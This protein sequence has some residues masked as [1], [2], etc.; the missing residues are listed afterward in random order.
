V[1]ASWTWPGRQAASCTCRLAAA[2]AT[3]PLAAPSVDSAVSTSPDTA[4]DAGQ[5]VVAVFDDPQTCDPHVAYETSSR[6]VVLNV[7]E[8]LLGFDETGRRLVPRLAVEVP[9]AVD[10]I[11]YRFRIR[12]GVVTHRGSLLGVADVVYSLRRAVIAA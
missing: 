2:A 1:V 10:G 7:Y 4:A 5:L 8:S 9:K 6:H 12:E 3:P 11:A